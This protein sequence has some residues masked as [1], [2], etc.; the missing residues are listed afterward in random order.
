MSDQ[1]A[2]PSTAAKKAEAI[3]EPVSF[4]YKDHTYTIPTGKQIPMDFLEA[5]EDDRGEIQIIRTLV[6]IEQWKAFKAT[7]PTVGD[8]E[9]FAGLVS[10]A[11]GFGET[12]N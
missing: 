4:D 3:D 9:T 7:D 11:A 2:K 8:F 5:V 1:T 10:T 12:G 6:G